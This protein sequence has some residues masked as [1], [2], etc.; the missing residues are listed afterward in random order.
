MSEPAL[1]PGQ[2][3]KKSRT[4]WKESS[5]LRGVW[6][7]AS[8]QQLFYS[9]LFSPFPLLSQPQNCSSSGSEAGG[10]GPCP[11]Q[12]ED[13]LSGLGLSTLAAHQQHL[14]VWNKYMQVPCTTTLPR[15][16]FKRSGGGWR[17][18]HLQ[19]LPTDDSHQ[20]LIDT[21]PFDVVRFP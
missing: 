12:P 11:A 1:L 3:G 20:A 7:S 13:V 21:L 9:I 18:L 2:P 8:V 15:L 14:W 5:H 19:T 16:E 4:S 10:F 6:I 17:G